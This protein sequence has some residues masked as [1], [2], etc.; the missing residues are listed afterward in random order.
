MTKGTL[1]S[2]SILRLSVVCG[3]KPLF[4]STTSTAMSAAEPPLDLRFV[5][6]S[7]P[8]VSITSMPGIGLPVCDS[9]LP[10]RAGPHM[11][12]MTSMGRKLAPM[13]CVMPPASLPC[14]PVPRMRSS[15]EVLPLSTWPRTAT[16]GWRTAP[17]SGACSP[18]WVAG[19][20]LHHPPKTT[21]DS[22]SKLSPESD[23]C[24]MLSVNP[25]P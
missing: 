2:P 13:C 1:R 23:A 22:C 17:P 3:W 6:T 9:S 14:T 8:G 12:R 19:N 4:A 20:V 7:C 25:R 21:L 10:Y 24:M 18:F 16:M 5:N 11:F 15:S